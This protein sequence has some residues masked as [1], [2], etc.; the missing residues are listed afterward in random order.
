MLVNLSK[1]G[2]QVTILK[3]AVETMLMRAHSRVNEDEIK[4]KSQEISK[5]GETQRIR[6]YTWPESN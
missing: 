2:E 5:R 4:W 6:M 1:Q 3:G